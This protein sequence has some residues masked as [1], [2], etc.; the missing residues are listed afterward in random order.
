M[1]EIKFRGKRIDNGE[2]IYGYY[3]QGASN[4]SNRILKHGVAEYNSYPVE[5]DPNTVCQFTGQF[6]MYFHEIYE[7]DIFRNL[8]GYDY[9]IKFKNGAFLYSDD[10][11]FD[12]SALGLK[13][14]NIYDN[15]EL[16]DC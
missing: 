15:P 8:K 4:G 7:N 10:F 13:V 11:I 5:V 3:V 2:W 1:R 12:D 6:D 14:G 9:V 16:I